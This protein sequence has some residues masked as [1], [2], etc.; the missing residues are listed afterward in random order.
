VCAGGQYGVGGASMEVVDPHVEAAAGQIDG[1][2]FA[3]IPKSDEAVAQI[4]FLLS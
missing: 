1:Q 3:E 4:H 2:V